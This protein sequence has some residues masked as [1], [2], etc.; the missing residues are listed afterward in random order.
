[1]P[2]T[3]FIMYCVINYSR[4]YQVQNQEASKS[5]ND[6]VF[7]LRYIEFISPFVKWG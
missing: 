5:N 2:E 4:E 1:M 7:E 3:N 6:S